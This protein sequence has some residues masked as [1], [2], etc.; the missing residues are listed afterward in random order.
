MEISLDE[1]DI[2][3]RAACTLGDI[4]RRMEGIHPALRKMTQVR[5]LL[6]AWCT[7]YGMKQED[8]DSELEAEEERQELERRDRD[9]LRGEDWS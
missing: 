1:Q 6:Q 2:L 9:G 3:V 5:S 4:M 7:V 8:E